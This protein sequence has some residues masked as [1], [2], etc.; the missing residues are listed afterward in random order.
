MITVIVSKWKENDVFN[1]FWHTFNTTN[2]LK[3][4]YERVS[5]CLIV[6]VNV[7]NFDIGK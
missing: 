1:S 5:N 6:N 7:L 3:V 4:L 2:V